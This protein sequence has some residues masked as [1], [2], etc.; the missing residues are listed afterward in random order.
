[1]VRDGETQRHCGDVYGPGSVNGMTLIVRQRGDGTLEES[2]PRDP[3]SMDG[4]PV[5]RT[6]SSP[7]LQHLIYHLRTVV[8][9]FRETGPQ[10]VVLCPLKVDHPPP[11][12]SYRTLRPETAETCFTRSYRTSAVGAESLE[13]TAENKT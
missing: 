5:S 6:V 3:T 2:C 9:G 8:R 11:V 1:M 10:G 13:G 12:S 7:H 4:T